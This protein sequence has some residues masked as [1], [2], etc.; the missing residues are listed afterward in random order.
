MV[1]IK[2]VKLSTL[3]MLII[4]PVCMHAQEA[5]STSG[6]S[7]TGRGGLL[8][9]TVGQ[10]VYTTNIVS[11]GSMSQGV[12][13]PFN[14]S[15]VTAI[16]ENKQISLNVTEYPNPATNYLILRMDDTFLLTDY[17]ASVFD[18]NGKLVINKNIETNQ[19]YI[20]MGSLAP[21]IYFLKV[22]QGNTEVKIFKI[23]KQ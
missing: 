5:I 16:Y 8:S 4:G 22:K 17:F 13:Q 3:I 2:S 19:T 20:D 6:G 15:E 21:A 14:I 12:Q 11:T 9:Y 7:A 1:G 23:I 18:L 10:V